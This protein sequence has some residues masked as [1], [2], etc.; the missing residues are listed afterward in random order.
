MNKGIIDCLTNPVKCR[1]LLE[2]KLKEKITAKQLAKIHSDI[3]QATLYR[4]LNKMVKDEIIKVVEE[5]Q[6]R[7]TVEKVYAV[8]D[9]S[10]GVEK[11]LEENSGEAYMQI[12]IQYIMGFMKEFQEYTSQPNI[13]ILNDGSGFTTAPFYATNEELEEVRI[14][15]GEALEPLIKN[16]PTPERK[17]R[18]LGII[19]TPPKKIK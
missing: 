18:S 5:N 12:F 19:V 14:K 17:L 6:I 13:D 10:L 15:L 3:P 1:M 4:Y 16:T 9:L 8:N 7:G 11:M 2:I